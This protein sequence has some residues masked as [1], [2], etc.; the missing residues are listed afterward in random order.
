MTTRR[1]LVP[2]LEDEITAALIALEETLLQIGGYEDDSTAQGDD[3]GLGYPLA[4]RAALEAVRSLWDALAPSQ[5]ERARKAC[6]GTVYA[7]D[8]RY[9]H[10][11]LRLVDVAVADLEVL[12]ATAK[13]F[14]APTDPYGVVADIVTGFGRDQLHGEDLVM[15]TAQLAG[16]LDLQAD[17]DSRALEQALAATGPTC[18]LT[19]TAELEQAYGAFV[20]RFNHMWTLADPLARWQY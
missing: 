5:G 11:P 4:S 3:S 14:A 20:D 19:F 10:L 1:V 6:L 12:A 9:E 15:R 8:G 7:P 13:A 16:V 17:D 2:D 18:D